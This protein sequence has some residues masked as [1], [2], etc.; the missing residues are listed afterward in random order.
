[1][2]TSSRATLTLDQSGARTVVVS[3]LD[4]VL[5]ESANPSP[6]QPTPG[7]GFRL[8]WRC[9]ARARATVVS[10]QRINTLDCSSLQLVQASCLARCWPASFVAALNARRIRAALKTESLHLD[11]YI[12]LVDGDRKRLGDVGPFRQLAAGR[13]DHGI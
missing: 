13:H 10:C 11:E 1:M 5:R 6:F 12:T 9:G 7:D 4:T 3:S 8:A 2:P